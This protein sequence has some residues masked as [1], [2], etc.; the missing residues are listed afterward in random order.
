VTNSPL[1]NK[2]VTETFTQQASDG[3]S[4]ALKK[5]LCLFASYFNG[6]HYRFS[7]DNSNNLTL[8]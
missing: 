1:V 2:T 7:L 3:L 4:L 5:A 8:S 6:N